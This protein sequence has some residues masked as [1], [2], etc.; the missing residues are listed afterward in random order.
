MFFL[1]GLQGDLEKKKIRRVM[2]YWLNKHF[3]FLNG[4]QTY[5]ILLVGL[6]CFNVNSHTRKYMCVKY[7]S[8][9]I[10]YLISICLCFQP[11]AFPLCFDLVIFAT[12]PIHTSVLFIR[13]FIVNQSTIC[14]EKDI[15][16]LRE[17]RSNVTRHI[18]LRKIGFVSNRLWFL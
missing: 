9:R 17:N 14:M 18:N 12:I 15:F 16:R 11:Y 8:K 2:K 5:D 7:V 6:I 3:L 1:F 13:F 4:R 10:K